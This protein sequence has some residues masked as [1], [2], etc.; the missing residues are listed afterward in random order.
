M[1]KA[2]HIV[3]RAEAGK[4]DIFRETGQCLLYEGRTD[5][6]LKQELLGR[7]KRV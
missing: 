2:T 7:R 3:E 6:G 5:E 1:D 4:S